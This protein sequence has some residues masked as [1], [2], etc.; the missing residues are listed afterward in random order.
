MPSAT[1][2]RSPIR[3][4]LH[5]EHRQLDERFEELVNAAEAGV[6]KRTLGQIWSHFDTE[7]RAHFALEEELVFPQLA[8]VHADAVREIRAEHDAIRARLDALD[9][10]VDL[11]FVRSHEV[12]ELVE[13]LRAHAANEDAHLYR[14]AETEPALADRELLLQRLRDQTR[15][16]DE[17]GLQAHLAQLE[18]SEPSIHEP[19]VHEEASAL[20]T[21]RDTLRLQIHL[22]QLDARDEWG[23]LEDRW[24]T[25]IQR[26]LSPRIDELATETVQFTNG[27]LGE[28]RE[29]Y[30]R[31]LD[32]GSR[33]SI[34]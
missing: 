5:D 12:T 18:A 1:S 21:M 19:G 6:D 28:V 11:H 13:R 4:A 29:A 31:L 3:R 25:F 33:A 9:V 24:R 15:I 16:T 10:A 32:R 8:I 27:M 7:V 22:G 30:E 34:R 2:A 20:A 17:L 23:K 26:D 14:W